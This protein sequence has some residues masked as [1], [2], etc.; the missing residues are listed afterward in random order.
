MRVALIIVIALLCLNVAG[1]MTFDGIRALTVGD[2]LTPKAGRH[3]GP[4]GPWKHAVALVG[5]EP[6]S[7]LMKWIFVTYGSTWLAILVC[8]LIKVD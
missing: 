4:L 5:I 8:F 3:A 7:N 2:Y 1:F 6:R